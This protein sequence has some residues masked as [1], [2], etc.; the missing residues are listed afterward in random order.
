M[1]SNFEDCLGR[2]QLHR[3]LDQID[4]SDLEEDWILREC[5][6]SRSD[7]G[8]DVQDVLG[9]TPL[10]IACQKGWVHGVSS[11]LQHGAD[12]SVS[13]IYGSL[14]LH[15]AAAQ[16]SHHIYQLLSMNRDN[17]DFEAR[18]C[19]EKTPFQYA[20]LWGYEDIARLPVF[21]SSL[22]GGTQ[23]YDIDRYIRSRG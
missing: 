12:S 21:A 10:H 15:Y 19:A 20:E 8:F 14:T 23:K 5:I 6:E 1:G 2:T 17:V 16:G 18:D 9:R 7:E 22:L 4:P 13:T 3:L 11:M